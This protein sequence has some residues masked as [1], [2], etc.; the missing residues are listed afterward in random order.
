MYNDDRFGKKNYKFNKELSET[1]KQK[2]STYTAGTVR[3]NQKLKELAEYLKTVN[4]PTILVAFGDHLPNL[5]EV[6]NSYGFLK[7]IPSE[8]I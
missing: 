2:L 7:M 6:Y 4:Q 1:E 3:A 5:Q 8:L